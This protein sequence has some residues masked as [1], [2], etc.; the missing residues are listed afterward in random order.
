M[1]CNMHRTR[2]PCQSWVARKG[3]FMRFGLLATALVFLFAHAGGGAGAVGDAALPG[4]F[5]VVHAQQ[6]PDHL[7]F[8]TT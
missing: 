6:A 4:Q 2:S 8:V 5:G 7:P 3:S 1:R